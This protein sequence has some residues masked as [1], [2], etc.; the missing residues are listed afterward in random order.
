MVLGLLSV[1]MGAQILMDTQGDQCTLR[2][3]NVKDIEVMCGGL[4][5]VEVVGNVGVSSSSEDN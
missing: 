5:L 4:V 1:C 2:S 3:D